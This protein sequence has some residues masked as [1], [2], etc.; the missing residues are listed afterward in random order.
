MI[1][2]NRV[3]GLKKIFLLDV[4]LTNLNYFG[5]INSNFQIGDNNVTEFISPSSPPKKSSGFLGPK[6][7]S[8]RF[9]RNPLQTPFT[10]AFFYFVFLL[11]MLLFNIYVWVQIRRIWW[12]RK[13]QTPIFRLEAQNFCFPCLTKSRT[14][15]TL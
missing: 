7:S 4:I 6:K 3:E 15:S 1:G 12:Y 10:K 2:S 9:L 11:K 13:K 8:E 14:N 5:E